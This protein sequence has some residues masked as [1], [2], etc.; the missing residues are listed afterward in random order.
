MND[1]YIITAP[2]GTVDQ[3]GGNEIAVIST[4][5]AEIDFTATHFADEGGETPS[6]GDYAA[7]II[8]KLGRDYFPGETWTMEEQL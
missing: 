3:Y 1:Q 5:L 2:D 4:V 7:D 6:E 8:R